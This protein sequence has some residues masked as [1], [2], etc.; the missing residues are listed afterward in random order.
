VSRRY[1]I[2][3]DTREAAPLLTAVW[4]ELGVEFIRNDGRELPINLSEHPQ[5]AALC[6]YCAANPPRRREPRG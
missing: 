2:N 6:A 1:Y 5:Y 3:F 4:V